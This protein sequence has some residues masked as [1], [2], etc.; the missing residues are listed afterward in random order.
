MIKLVIFDVGGTLLDYRPALNRLNVK[1]LKK[2]YNI[3]VDEREV[4]KV[5]DETDSILGSSYLPKASADLLISK[6]ILKKFGIPI[7]NARNFEKEFSDDAYNQFVYKRMKLYSDAL[8]TIKKLKGKFLIATLANTSD[9]VFHKNILKKTKLKKH[10]HLYIDSDSVGIRKPNSKIFRLVLK[11]FN[12]KPKEAVMIG[13]T[14]SADILGAKKLGIKTILINRR[15][16]HFRFSHKTKPDFE[17]I[18]LNEISPIL[19]KLKNP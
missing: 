12:L 14:P 5:V 13:D 3:K 1:I 2:I 16:L 11:H 15:N 18:S 9:K 7:S 8:P 6:N 19:N 17:I 4:Q 10:F